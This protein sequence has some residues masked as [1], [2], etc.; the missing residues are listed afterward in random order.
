VEGSGPRMPVKSKTPIH[1]S[2]YMKGTA[3]I[4][5]SGGPVETKAWHEESS[6]V[7]G[8]FFKNISSAEIGSLTLYLILY[9]IINYMVN[10][11]P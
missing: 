4:P 8:N 11:L 6:V 2:V 1:G 3:P 5:G 10:H 7:L 9:S